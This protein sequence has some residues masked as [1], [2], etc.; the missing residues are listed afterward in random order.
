MRTKINNNPNCI[1]C[2]SS[3]VIK[4]GK[5]NSGNK[6]FKCKSCS[7]TWVD[8]KIIKERP[9]TSILIEKYFEGNSI[10]QLVPFYNASPQKINKTIREY[11][12]N[13]PNW[14]DYIDNLGLNNSHKVVYLI[15]Q[16]FS[17]NCEHDDCNN[18]FLALAVDA[19]SSFVLGYEISIS[20]T[21]DVWQKLIQNLSSRNIKVNTFISKIDDVIQSSIKEYYPSSRH[22]TNVIK[23]L[24]QKEIT[25]YINKLPIKNRLVFDAIKMYDTLD[26]KSLNQYLEKNKSSFGECLSVFQSEFYS[27]IEKRCQI[28]KDNNDELLNDFKDRFEKFHMIKCE[29]TPLINGWIAY[30]MLKKQPCGFS[31]LDFYKQKPTTSN[32]K[33]FS[34]KILP[35]DISYKDIDIKKFTFEIGTRLVQLPITDTKCDKRLINFS[36]Y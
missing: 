16:N 12:S 30:N 7:K 25:C 31:R 14:E 33:D 1:F 9:D 19:M 20:N 29:P 5:T 17:C 34:T 8:E 23:A 22:F 4:F 28:T 10:R 18:N 13:S 21:N 2:E 15:G 6:R 35:N 36:N 11:L 3:E 24:R 27:E 26:N 32:F